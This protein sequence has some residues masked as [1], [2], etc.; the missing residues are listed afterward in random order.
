MA[1]GLIRGTPR[2]RLIEQRRVSLEIVIDRATETLTSAGG[3]PYNGQ[4]Q[5]VIV[6]AVAI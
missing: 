1:T 5:A 4:A 3:D 6:E 2:A